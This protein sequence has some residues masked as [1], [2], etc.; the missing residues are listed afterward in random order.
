MTLTIEVPADVENA[1]TAAARRRGVALDAYLS[2][3]LK[4]EAQDN[5][6]AETAR[7]EAVR[8]GRG[9]FK[10]NGHET[11]DFMRERREEGLREMERDGLPTI[12]QNA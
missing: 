9:M 1:L 3:V 8:R 6:T 5:Q 7:R 11:E 10:G 12:G 2:E 4:R